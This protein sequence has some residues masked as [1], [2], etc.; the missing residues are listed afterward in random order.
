MRPTDLDGMEDMYPFQ[1]F[2]LY[3]FPPWHA[4]ETISRQLVARRNRTDTAPQPGHPSISET[5][6]PGWQFDLQTRKHPIHPP[7]HLKENNLPLS[8]AFQFP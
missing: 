3:D 1:A 5:D 4:I 2:F 8:G 6:T 7:T